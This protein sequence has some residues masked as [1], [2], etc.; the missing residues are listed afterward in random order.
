MTRLRYYI[1][2]ALEPV[3]DIRLVH[4]LRAAEFVAAGVVAWWWLFGGM[5]GYAVLASL[6]A[7]WLHQWADW[8]GRVK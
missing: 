6:A 7:I 1:L 4:L 8:L 2:N 5:I 3:L